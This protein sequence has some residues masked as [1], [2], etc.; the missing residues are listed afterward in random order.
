MQVFATFT[1]G[2][3]PGVA[4]WTTVAAPGLSLSA[5][6]SKLRRGRRTTVRFKVTDAGDPVAGAK[7]SGGGKSDT[8]DAAGK[9]SLALTGRGKRVHV[10][11]TRAG[12][13]AAAVNLRMR[14]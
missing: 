10:T 14:R 1:L 7:V 5:S 13:V 6:P 8:T 3:A 9:A 12:Y 4:T 2:A 11:A